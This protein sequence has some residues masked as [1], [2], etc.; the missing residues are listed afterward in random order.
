VHNLIIETYLQGKYDV[1]EKGACD[2]KTNAKTAQITN[3]LYKT[4]GNSAINL[5]IKA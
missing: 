4:I 5:V 3:K 1:Y 2:E